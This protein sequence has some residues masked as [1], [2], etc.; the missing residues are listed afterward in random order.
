MVVVMEKKR[1]IKIAMIGHKSIPS[2]QGGVEIVVEE[3]SKRLVMLGNEVTVYNRSSHHVSGKQYDEK[4]MSVYKGIKIKYVPTI[5]AKGLAAMSS[6]FFAAIFASLNNYDIVHFHAEGPAAMIWLPKLFGKKCIVTIHGLDHKREKWKGFAKK[7]ILFGEK[8]AVKFANE[9]IVLSKDEQDYFLSKYN[10]QTN[11]IPNGVNNPNYREAK[12]ISEKYGLEKDNYILFLG[13][14]VPEKGVK[15]LVDAFKQ[16]ETTKKLVIAG[17]SSDTDF[18]ANQI[19]EL[20][21]NDERIIFTGFVQGEELEE[22]YSN[23]YIYTL[24]SDLEGMPL[25]L[26]EAMSY[27]NA[28]LVSNIDECKSV[29]GDN[30]L[31]FKKSDVNDLKSKLEFACNNPNKVFALKKIASSYVLR[32]FNWDDVVNKTLQLYIQSLKG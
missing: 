31:I 4:K 20:A 3:L 25:S 26:L 22:L 8:C 12:I 5:D 21:K 9:I 6:S 13:R 17:S 18:F 23:A 2:R 32:K 19:K 29:V 16:V 10:R 24:P 1:K 28:C 15:Y 7:Y 30:A 27:G 11:L 14:I